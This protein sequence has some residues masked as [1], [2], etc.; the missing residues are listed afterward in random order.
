MKASDPAMCK[1]CGHRHYRYQP[2]VFPQE[3]QKTDA[4][5]PPEVTPDESSR[6]T[7]A[8]PLTDITELPDEELIKIRNIVMGEYMKRR[9]AREK[10]K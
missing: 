8:Y 7:V 9:R 5:I 6:E 10:K 1:V 2:H 4:S 3:H